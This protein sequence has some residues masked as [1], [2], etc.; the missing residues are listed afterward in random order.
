MLYIG[1]VLQPASLSRKIKFNSV[2]RKQAAINYYE[3]LISI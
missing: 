2:V 1:W 3:I